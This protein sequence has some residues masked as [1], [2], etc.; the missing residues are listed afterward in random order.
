[1][2]LPVGAVLAWV[3]GTGDTAGYLGL[4]S[5]TWK[6][7]IWG[8]LGLSILVGLGSLLITEVN[9]Q[10]KALFLTANP[11]IH[12]WLAVVLL[13]PLLEEWIFRGFVFDGLCSVKGGKW[14]ECGLTSLLWS[15][16]HLQY[17]VREMTVLF[18]LGL[19]LG[20]VRIRSA[21]IWPCILLHAI[22]NL[23]S[24]VIMEWMRTHGEL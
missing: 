6:P 14:M 22:N 24:T 17:G 1:M 5:F 9:P 4:R 13:A 3:R 11:R 2:L 18:S 20:W 12:L 7:M 21:S 19:L 23:M 15:L 10:M 16:I 8:L